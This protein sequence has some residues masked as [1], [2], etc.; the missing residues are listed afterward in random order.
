[1]SDEELV[2]L[3]SEEPVKKERSKFYDENT[4]ITFFLPKG[5]KRSFKALM[6]QRDLT[7]SLALKNFISATLESANK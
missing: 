3:I 1:M 5:M 6:K 2:K 7:I 4:N